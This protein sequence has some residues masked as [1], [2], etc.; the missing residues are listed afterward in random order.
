MGGTARLLHDPVFYRLGLT[1]LHFLWQGAALAL[2][3]WSLQL[4]LRRARPAARYALL[5][6]LL[7][8]MAMAPVL[9]FTRWAKSPPPALMSHTEVS[10]LLLK[11]AAQ[12]ARPASPAPTPPPALRLPALQD[13]IRSGWLWLRG[14]LPAAGALWLLGVL[15]LSAWLL[16]QWAG[17]LRVIR[18]GTPVQ[19]ARWQTAVAA[20]SARLGVRRAV[21][22]L[23]SL[24][25][26]TPTLVGWLRPVVLLPP[27]V[28]L[29]LTP[30]QVEAILAHELAHLRRH[31]FLVNVCQ[32]AVEVVL[33]YHPA[34]WW[35]SALIR[36]ERELCC[37]DLVV[38]AGI[39][40]AVY[41]RALVGLAASQPM[42]P[43]T[44]LAATRAAV[45]GR[46]RRLVLGAAA[47][48]RPLTWH[49]A[50]FP[51]AAL[52]AIA[53]VSSLAPLGA[54]PYMTGTLLYEESQSEIKNLYW[55]AYGDTMGAISGRVRW[56]A[57]LPAP[58]YPVSYSPNG[59]EAAFPVPNGE[60]CPADTPL[61]ERATD[62]WKAPLDLQG[63]PD[64]SRAVDLCA[65]AG[66][67]GG[68]NGR[69]AW[70]PDG[71]RIMWV[72]IPA[73]AGADWANQ[74]GVWV[75][76]ADGTGAHVL[77]LGGR[78]YMQGGAWTPDGSYVVVTAAFRQHASQ[79]CLS[80]EC[81]SLLVAADG[82]ELRELPVRTPSVSPD[83]EWVAGIRAYPYHGIIPV[84][85]KKWYKPKGTY[86]WELVLVHPDGTGLRKLLQGSYPLDG[87]PADPCYVAIY[88][89]PRD[90]AWS[91]DGRQLAFAWM[92]N[93][94]RKGPDAARQSEVYTYDLE[95]GQVTQITH[96]G[97][98]KYR[99]VWVE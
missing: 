5:L 31:D 81:D 50:I 36:K 17:L 57:K 72:H 23:Q 19:E 89:T 56:V 94:D 4:L 28:L 87:L 22:L 2:L 59:G 70:S 43:E 47:E 62:I 26:H 84:D 34:V 11:S 45:T 96:D 12:R 7:A 6:G 83:G 85:G 13:R 99:L 55:E 8:L 58:R 16:A 53:L 61:E 24:E 27:A 67:R 35:L 91:P 51:T 14:R 69:P 29:G 60:K 39:D 1:L 63:R 30:Q 32:Q 3:A 68:D 90:M 52:L 95:S 10:R 15:V 44:A 21:R 25:F 93:W 66:L 38:A 49:V 88:L 48:R 73:G 79:R 54:G 33:F 9:T 41:A 20:L 65:R 82:T 71:S 77:S 42:P 92:K 46:V 80:Q 78:N 37:D 18:R 98:Q 86:R 74:A 97:R 75:M 76:N 40:S 64:L